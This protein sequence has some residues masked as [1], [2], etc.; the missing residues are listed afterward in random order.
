MDLIARCSAFRTFLCASLHSYDQNNLFLILFDL[1]EIKGFHA[2]Q[3]CDKICLKHN[4]LR[5]L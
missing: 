2:K 4:L 5:F 1:F 3:F